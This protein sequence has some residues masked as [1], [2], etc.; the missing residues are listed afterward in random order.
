LRHL[1]LAAIALAALALAGCADDR[2]QPAAPEAPPLDLSYVGFELTIDVATGQVTVARPGT[3]AMPGGPSF[4]LLGAEAVGIQATACTFSAI[5]NNTKLKRC[6]GA[7]GD[8][9]PLASC[10]GR[11]IVHADR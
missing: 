10:L 8:A 11:Q 6:E 5:P 3:R 4:S 2:G 7:C 9:R 1:P